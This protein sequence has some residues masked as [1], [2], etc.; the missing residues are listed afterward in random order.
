MTP[1]HIY[2]AGTE[3]GP[4]KVGFSRNPRQRI[5]TLNCASPNDIRL[6]HCYQ[7]D[8]NPLHIERAVH[9]TLH[10]HRLAGEW[11]DVDSAS[12]RE[13]L[14]RTANEYGIALIDPPRPAKRKRGRPLSGKERVTIRL[15]ADVL[16]AYRSLGEGWQGILNGDLRKIRGI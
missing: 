7:V 3:E 12:A 13:A 11:F 6:L 10:S 14:L 15:D 1:Q 8:C 4:V 9:S 5:A 2:I 16:A